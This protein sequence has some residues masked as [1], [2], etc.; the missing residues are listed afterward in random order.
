MGKAVAVV[1]K[2]K[3]RSLELSLGLSFVR[4]YL[5]LLY[6]SI[7]SEDGLEHMDRDGLLTLTMEAERKLGIVEEIVELHC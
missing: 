1:T 5:N 6:N 7:S 2:E 3:D 4:G